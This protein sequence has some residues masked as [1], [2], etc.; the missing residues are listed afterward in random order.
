MNNNLKLLAVFAAV[1]LAGGAM[2]APMHGAKPALP[3]VKVELRGAG[4]H[5]TAGPVGHHHHH[6]HHH[7]RHQLPPPPPPPPAP[8]S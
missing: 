5:M 3:T 8:K 6:H 2:A 4:G 7:G 1:A